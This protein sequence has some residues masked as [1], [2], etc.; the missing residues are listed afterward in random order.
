[1]RE[2][3]GLSAGDRLLFEMEGDGIRLRVVKR[4]ALEELRG[5]LPATCPYLGKEAEREVARRS[6]VRKTLGENA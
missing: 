6:V 5:S 3:L 1:M 4:K 2:R